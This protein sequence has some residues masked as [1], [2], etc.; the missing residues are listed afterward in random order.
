MLFLTEEQKTKYINNKSR[1]GVIYK[2]TN[3][4]NGDFYIGSTQNLIKRYYTHINHIRVKKNTCTLLIRA[5]NKYGEDNFRF[6]IIEECDNN[7]LL[8]REQ[9]YLDSLLPKYNISKVAGSNLGIKRSELVKKNKSE[10]QKKNWVEVDYRKKHLELLSKNWKSGESHKMAKLNESQ[11]LEIKKSI[12]QGLLPKQISETLQ[13]SYH[14]IKDI[15]RGKTW[16]HI[17]I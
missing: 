5:V 4:V 11:V 7:I 6:E 2:I 14:S 15:Y 9:Y 12:K 17:S 8:E 3:L 13:L 16:K 10:S 1:D